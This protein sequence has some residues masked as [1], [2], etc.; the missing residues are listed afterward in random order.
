MF[1]RNIRLIEN[2][3]KI[4]ISNILAFYIQQN[5][6]VSNF[7]SSKSKLRCSQ[8]SNLIKIV[9]VFGSTIQKLESI[10]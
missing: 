9:S 8:S 10:I 4:T 6:N 7:E 1:S 2:M 5:L 3:K